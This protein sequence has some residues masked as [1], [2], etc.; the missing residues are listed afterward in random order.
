M[1]HVIYYLQK[2]PSTSKQWFVEGQLKMSLAVTFR[3][4][5]FGHHGG[6]TRIHAGRHL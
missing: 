5:V 6:S 3:L 2:L 4:D 1:C